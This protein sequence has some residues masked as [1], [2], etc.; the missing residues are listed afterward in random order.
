MKRDLITNLV[1]NLIIAE[2]VYFM[3]FNFYAQIKKNDIV[4]ISEVL[5]NKELLEESL[6]LAALRVK[7]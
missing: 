3:I 4:A 1:T 6:S 7:P 5:G 2:D